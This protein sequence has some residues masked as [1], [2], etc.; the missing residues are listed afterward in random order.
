[1][2]ITLPLTTYPAGVILLPTRAVP[3]GLVSAT[4]LFD[5]THVTTLTLVMQVALELSQDNGT[6]WVPSGGSTLSLPNCGCTLSGG[7]LTDA[8]GKP[9]LVSGFQIALANPTNAQ[10]RIRGTVTL[11]ESFETQVTVTVL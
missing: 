4:A 6:T 3:T 8:S 11:S 2:T 10:R 1:M 7:V 9:V 5:T